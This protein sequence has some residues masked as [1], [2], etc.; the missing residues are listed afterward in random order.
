MT[1]KRSAST[2]ALYTFD[3]LAM[4]T[5]PSKLLA[6]GLRTTCFTMVYEQQTTYEQTD[7]YVVRKPCASNKLGCIW[8]SSRKYYGI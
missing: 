6:Q 5:H 2:F 3:C 4:Q 1:I 8:L 7:H